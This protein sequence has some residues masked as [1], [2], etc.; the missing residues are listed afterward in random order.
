MGTKSIFLVPL[1]LDGPPLRQVP[2]LPRLRP[3]ELHRALEVRLRDQLGSELLWIT[4]P[5]PERGH[6]C[7]QGTG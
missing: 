4:P 5:V 3:R 2:P 7:Q 1:R 6:L